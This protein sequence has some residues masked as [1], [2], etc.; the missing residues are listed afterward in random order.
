MKKHIFKIVFLL[1]ALCMCASL[2]ACA[3][4]VPD[5]QFETTIDT[6]SVTYDEV[7]KTSNVRLKVMIENK[8]ADMDIDGF[9]YIV[10]YFT[11]DGVCL[12]EEKIDCSSETL[13]SNS[14]TITDNEYTV[15]GNV[16]YAV[17]I[18]YSVTVLPKS[19]SSEEEESS[20]CDSCSDGNWFTNLLLIGGGLY[21]AWKIFGED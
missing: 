17:V 16:T 5:M 11:A 19:E 21:L 9:S 4:E 7:S 6:C 2:F 10:R 20:G 13:Y 14:Y 18:P 1:T 15:S 3:A 12:S 8:S